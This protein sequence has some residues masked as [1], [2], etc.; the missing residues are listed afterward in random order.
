MFTRQNQHK[1]TSLAHPTKGQK[2]GSWIMS[3][4]GRDMEAEEA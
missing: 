3:K 1:Y 2:L 4:T